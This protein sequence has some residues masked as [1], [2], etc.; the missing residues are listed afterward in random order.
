VEFNN[1]E[2]VQFTDDD[3]HRQ[4]H[5]NLQCDLQSSFRNSFASIRLPLKTTVHGERMR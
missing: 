2:M 1:C 5:Q 4:S 3:S